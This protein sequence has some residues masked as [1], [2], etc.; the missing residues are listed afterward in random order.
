MPSNNLSVVSNWGEKHNA[1]DMIRL[2]N[3]TMREDAMDISDLLLSVRTPTQQELKITERFSAY[4]ASYMSNCPWIDERD[5]E[6]RKGKA[7]NRNARRYC[8][9]VSKDEL[10]NDGCPSGVLSTHI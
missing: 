9:S 6:S 7:Y 1:C 4:N 2:Q 3:G 8:V 5:E 10:S